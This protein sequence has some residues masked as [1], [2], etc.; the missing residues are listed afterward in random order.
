[1]DRDRQTAKMEIIFCGCPEPQKDDIVQHVPFDA[2]TMEMV[3]NYK[4][5]NNYCYIKQFSAL[6]FHAS[7]NH[8]VQILATLMNQ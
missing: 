1:M 7:Y 4:N 8:T 2:N 3:I 5:H 6:V